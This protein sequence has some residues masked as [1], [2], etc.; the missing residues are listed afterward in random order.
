MRAALCRDGVRLSSSPGR[1]LAAA[2][3]GAGVGLLARVTAPPAGVL[4]V[5]AAGAQRFFALFSWSFPA[6][7]LLGAALGWAL[8]RA[9]RRGLLPLLA[10]RPVRRVDYVLGRTGAVLSAAFATVA[11]ALAAAAAAAGILGSPLPVLERR[12]PP[13]RILVGDRPVGRD[14]VA[15]AERGR[16]ARFSFRPPE[17][18][19]DGARIEIRPRVVRAG[20]FSGAIDL[21]LRWIDARGEVHALPRPPSRPARHVE[22]PLGSSVREPFVLVVEPAQEG[23]ALAVHRD[24]ATISGGRRHALTDAAA[25]GLALALGGGAVAS[26]SFALA[27]VLR[28]GVALLAIA[29]VLVVGLFAPALSDVAARSGGSA[30]ARAIARFVLAATPDLSRFDLSG[31]FARGEAIGPS[32]LAAAGALFVTVVAAAGL[33]ATALLPFEESSA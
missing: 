10:V 8:A 16:P 22:I 9:D 12:L 3:V 14:E 25:A 29:F 23:Y 20:R 30:A 19:T 1:L 24:T 18:G 31:P 2:A 26:L 33:L 6:A 15:W 11:L 17:E 13:E 32:A 28:G 4:P 21:D 5:E 27:L 7:L